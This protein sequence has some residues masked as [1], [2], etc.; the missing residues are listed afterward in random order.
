MKLQPVRGTHDIL[1]EEYRLFNHVVSKAREISALYGF[2][3]I[4]TPI[5]EFTEVF[6]RTLGEESDVV[7]KEMYTFDDR[8]GD[9]IT[10][11][12]EFTAGIA[13]AFISNGL[14]QNLPVKAFTTGPIFRYERPQKGR[15]RQ[16][17]QINFE[18]IGPA[19]PQA[20]IE[21]IAMGW[22]IISALGLQDKVQL[23]INSLGDK[24]SRDNYKVGLVRYL[25]QY[26]EKLS[27]DSQRRLTTNP[28]RILDSKNEGDKEIVKD[29]PTIE[30]YYTEVSVNFFNAVKDGLAA[31]GIPYKLNN[32]LVRGLDYYCH[33]AFEFT[34]TALG[35]QNAVMAGGRY[36]GLIHTMGGPEVPAVG[37]GGGIERL[38][39][40]C[41]RK[42]DPVRPVVLI[43][44]GGEAEKQA[45]SLAMELRRN[46]LYTELG[47]SGNVKKRF[48]KADS[49]NAAAAIV[50]GDEELK[51]SLVKIKDFNTGQEE[52]VKLSD[53]ID[54][55]SIYR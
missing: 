45:V 32:K 3:Q 36:D 40:L 27:E 5:F 31:L 1:F 28:M 54:K 20:D 13:R 7:G 2:A 38:A 14:Q 43:P 53:L 49:I 39:L 29:A 55:L 34:T 41:D 30:E 9:S 19:E 15:M 46:G 8:G 21:V 35:A 33:T 10:L 26:K 4:A 24:Q 6:K 48:K 16:F 22:H 51:Q 23:E 47:Y 50:F 17:H 42:I 12:P 25:S 52:G 11:R 37:F 44:I 18:L